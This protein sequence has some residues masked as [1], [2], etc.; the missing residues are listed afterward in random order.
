MQSFLLIPLFIASL[1]SALYPSSLVYQFPKGTWVENLAVR[2]SGTVLVTT[3]LPNAAVYEINPNSSTTPKVVAQFSSSLAALGIT[4]TTPDTFYVVSNNVSTAT[5]AVAPGSNKIWRLSFPGPKVALVSTVTNA[6][7]LNGLTTLNSQ[8]ILA[9]D[10]TAGAVWAINTTSGAYKK[11]ISDPLMS[12]PASEKVVGLNG[13]KITGSTLYFTN[14]AQKVFAKIPLNADGTPTT[15]ATKVASSTNVPV[16]NTESYD[17]F[18]LDKAGNTAYCVV[19]GGNV[20]QKVVLASGST[21]IV[22]GNLNSTDLAEPTSG[23]FGRTTSDA[24]TLYVT[25]SGAIN[26]PVYKNG[27]KYQDIGGQLVAV[28]TS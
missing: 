13:L 7:F 16:A 8:T 26:I 1:C 22:A 24:G 9:A 11:V 15:S 18:G 20:I 28:K 14:T 4:E 23:Q 5:G 19:G 6:S 21:S 3:I 2:S 25:T 17:D 10:A 12:K 27:V